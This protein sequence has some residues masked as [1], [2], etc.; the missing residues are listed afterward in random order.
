MLVP[1]Y[2]FQRLSS[3][4]AVQCMLCACFSPCLKS[5]DWLSQR[6]DFSG[7][8][9]L[10]GGNGGCG[11][12]QF[13]GT[14]CWTGGCGNAGNV[15]ANSVGKFCQP[16]EKCTD[17]KFGTNGNCNAR[18]KNVA[19]ARAKA[20]K[21][22]FKLL[23]WSAFVS[24]TLIH[25]SERSISIW[26]AHATEPPTCGAKRGW[27]YWMRCGYVFFAGDLLPE[28]L[29]QTGRIHFQTT[30]VICFCLPHPD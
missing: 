19:R 1:S 4:S 26:R 20:G 15:G 8:Y 3:G 21:C 13:C 11:S 14:K 6:Y 30:V 22:S 2:V 28:F 27:R 17:K 16:C 24:T 5:W 23:T 25:K 29:T 12:T 10:C 9:R 18:C 7:S